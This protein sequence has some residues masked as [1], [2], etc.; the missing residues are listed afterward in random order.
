MKNETP[1]PILAAVE[2]HADGSLCGW[3]PFC[4]KWHYHGIGEGHRS[5]HCPHDTPFKKTGYELK[6][7][8][9]PAYIKE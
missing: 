3:C 6:K 2:Y 4:R 8:K 5:A 9:P 7:V 1:S